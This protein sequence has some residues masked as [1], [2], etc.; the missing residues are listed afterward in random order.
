MGMYRVLLALAVVIIH[1]GASYGLLTPSQAVESFF[2]ISGFYMSLILN[3]KYVGAGSYRLFITNRLLRIYPLYWFVL[4]ITVIAWLISIK[5]TGEAGPFG[6]YHYNMS[7]SG[8]I[9]FHFS[10]L[11]IIG[12]DWVT[13]LGMNHLGRLYI[14]KGIKFTNPNLT[15]FLFVP[16]AWSLALELTFYVLAP[17][18]VRRTAK[19]ILA[20]IF[21]SFVLRLVL[22][23]GFHLTNDPWSYRL[24][25]T[26]LAFF[27]AGTLSY[28]IYRALDARKLP[29]AFYWCITISFLLFV[30]MISIIPV[31]HALKH[32]GFHLLAWIAIPFMFLATRSSR[33]DRYIGELSYP[34]YIGHWLV[35][36]FLPRLLT[37]AGISPTPTLSIIGSVIFAILLVHLVLGPIERFRA[38]RFRNARARVAEN[39]LAIPVIPVA[40]S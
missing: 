12:Q 25:P 29:Q 24:F 1:V 19:V 7:L 20:L 18:I 2:V 26:E 17:W 21:A 40:A 37:V 3:E 32:V 28:K 11:A 38:R 10:N 14:A 6:I 23:F 39:E 16:P 15:T 33:I 34:I 36:M 27:L 30:L 9:L 8:L 22:Y 35:L 13:F 5:L 31:S 4:I